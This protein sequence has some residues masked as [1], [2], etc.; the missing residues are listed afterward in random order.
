VSVKRSESVDLVKVFESEDIRNNNKRDR[1]ASSYIFS[2]VSCLCNTN[3]WLLSLSCLLNHT[4]TSTNQQ[5]L[6]QHYPRLCHD[7]HLFAMLSKRDGVS[8]Q[9]KH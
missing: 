9:P 2:G 1:H 4:H 3:R 5:L 6:H 8:S 7:L